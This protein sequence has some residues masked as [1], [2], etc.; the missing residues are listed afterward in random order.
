MNKS[1]TIRQVVALTGLSVHTLRYY[2]QIGLL[3]SINRNDHGH[4]CYTF[5]D[6]TWIEFINRL[7]ATGMSLTNM[8]EIAELKRKGDSTL[9]TRRILLEEHY[10]TV[11]K[12]II[13]LQNNLKLLEEKIITYKEMENRYALKQKLIEQPTDRSAE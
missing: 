12:A 11:Q 3:T 10:T 4:R 5:E 9:T 1:L 8:L 2:E 6:V 7:K 13:E